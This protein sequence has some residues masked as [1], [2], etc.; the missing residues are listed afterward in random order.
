MSEGPVRFEV[1]DG[2]AFLTIAREKALNALNGDVIAALDARVR[3]VEEN[4]DIAG[5]LITGA[6]PKAFV[7]GA[8][9]GEL[10]EISSVR[11]GREMVRRGQRV[12]S[13]IEGLDRPVLACI[14]G[15]ALGGGLELALSCH[16]RYAVQGAQL[17]LPEVKL[18]V[19][20][21]YGGTQRLARIVGR[22]IAT[23]MIL[24]GDF[25]P[26][27]EAHRIG[28]VNRVFES[29]DEMLAAGEKLLRKIASRGPLAVRAALEAVDRGL[30]LGLHEGLRVEADLFAGL[31]QTA[32]MKEG[33]AAF[34]EK[35]DAA[36]KGE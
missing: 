36:F 32:D 23:E 12:L 21:G 19:I 15:F 27:P 20:P 16:M 11:Q 8:D 6:G 4:R 30:S 5:L 9:I 24:S 26:A 34:L 28:L 1:R 10:A 33:L 2:L 31:C 3:E 29:A 35:R 25:T 13:R 22:G 18:G 17:G 7:A 14:N